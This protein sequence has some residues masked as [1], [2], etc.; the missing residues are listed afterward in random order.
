MTADTPGEEYQTRCTSIS[1]L[2]GGG[3]SEDM[4]RKEAIEWMILRKDFMVIFMQ[5]RGGG[6]EKERFELLFD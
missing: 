3:G 5:P 4:L 6:K 2:S 1:W